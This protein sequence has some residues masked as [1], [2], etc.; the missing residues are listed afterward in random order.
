MEEFITSGDEEGLRFMEVDATN[1]TVVLVEP[2]DDRAHAVV[3]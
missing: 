2:I 3:P 1:G